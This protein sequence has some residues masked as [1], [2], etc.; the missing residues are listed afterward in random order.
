QAVAGQESPPG[1]GGAGRGLGDQQMT[2]ADLFEQARVAARIEG[3]E[4]AGQDRDGGTVICGQ[5][6]AV[7]GG[8]DAVGSARDHGPS[9]GGEGGGQGGGGV[10][11]IGRRGAG[12]DQGDRTG[13]AELIER[14][15]SVHP[16]AVRRGLLQVR[17]L[18]RPF[19]VLRG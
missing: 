3:V 6:S 16:Q 19:L 4:T 12:A 9:A 1:R 10:L 14:A 18:L 13:A 15:W 7:G 11:A 5:G 17:Q 8:V 2:F